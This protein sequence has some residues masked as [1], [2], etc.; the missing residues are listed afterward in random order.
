MSA[1]RMETAASS[2]A[3]GIAQTRTASAIDAACAALVTLVSALPYVSHLGFYSDDW[4]LLAGFSTPGPHSIEGDGFPGRPIQGIYLTLLFRAFGLDPLGYHL[5]NTAVLAVSA[6]LLCSLLARLR[7]GRAQSFATTILFVMLPQLSTVRVWYAAFQVP[8]SMMLMLVC[9]H[10]Q[11]SF[12]RS[13]KLAFA[14]SD[15]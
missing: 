2:L 11:L 9:M 8:L 10:C 15:G 6:A 1:G 12:S 13:G 14:T 4:G 7:V 5:V 3:R